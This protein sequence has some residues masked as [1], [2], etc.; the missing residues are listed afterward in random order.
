MVKLAL[1]D[2][3]QKFEVRMEFWQ[4]TFKKNEIGGSLRTAYIEYYNEIF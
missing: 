1:F 4:Y 2:V 3:S